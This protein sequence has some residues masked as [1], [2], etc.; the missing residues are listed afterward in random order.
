MEFLKKLQFIHMLTVTFFRELTVPDEL[1]II[2]FKNDILLHFSPFIKHCINAKNKMQ[3]INNFA[4]VTV[5]A[6]NVLRMYKYI[7]HMQ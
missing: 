1:L 7:I 3:I 6:L 2:W 4:T 5:K